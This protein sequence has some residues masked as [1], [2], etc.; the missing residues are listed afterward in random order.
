MIIVRLLFV[1]V[2]ANR[3]TDLQAAYNSSIET[4]CIVTFIGACM[5]TDKFFRRS[6]F[7]E[8][9]ETIRIPSNIC[10]VPP[11]PRTFVE[12]GNSVCNFTEERQTRWNSSG[13][14]REAAFFHQFIKTRDFRPPPSC[15]GRCRYLSNL[16]SSSLFV[17]QCYTA[18]NLGCHPSVPLVNKTQYCAGLSGTD[19]CPDSCIYGNEPR[20][21][22]SWVNASCPDI[23]TSWRNT[24]LAKENKW[25]AKWIYKTILPWDWSVQRFRRFAVRSST[26]I[27]ITEPSVSSQPY[28]IVQPHG[29]GTCA[30]SSSQK[31]GVFAALNIM[32]ACLLPIFGRRTFIN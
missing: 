5:Q 28:I 7:C 14:E 30:V 12:W 21:F 26:G 23:V 18:D 25:L 4:W 9:L 29:R 11:G 1:I 16:Y 22:Y 20:G 8:V 2:C 31:L 24:T 17:E 15:S 32:S 19:H 10:I 27:E 6:Q 13:A 3:W